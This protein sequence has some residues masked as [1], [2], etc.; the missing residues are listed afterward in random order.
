MVCV[1]LTHSLSTFLD[2]H[3]KQFSYEKCQKTISCTRNPVR[4]RLFDAETYFIYS[5]CLVCLCFVCLFPWCCARIS[6]RQHSN[7]YAHRCCCTC[8]NVKA[9]ETIGSNRLGIVVQNVANQNH[10]F[11]YLNGFKSNVAYFKY[12]HTYV[13]NP[14]DLR[15]AF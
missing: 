8:A 1:C 9:I 12:S 11:E 5:L 2:A 4:L 6:D 3:K 13:M 15:N 7:C 14:L 10:I